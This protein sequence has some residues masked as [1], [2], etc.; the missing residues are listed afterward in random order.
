MWIW[1]DSHVSSELSSTD[2]AQLTLGLESQIS[3]V[4]I[5]RVAL[6]LG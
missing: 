4:S 2:S 5:L 3:F 1:G 6:A